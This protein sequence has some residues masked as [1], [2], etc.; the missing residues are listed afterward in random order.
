MADFITA[1]ITTATSEGC[2]RATADAATRWSTALAG[3]DVGIG[4]LAAGVSVLLTLPDGTEHD[5]AAARWRG[6]RGTGGACAELRHPLGGPMQSGRDGVVV[7]FGRPAEHA[8]VAAVVALRNV[9]S[10]SGLGGDA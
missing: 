9:L 2:V 6:R 8:F 1:V 10:A 4:G 3:F 5:G 7:G